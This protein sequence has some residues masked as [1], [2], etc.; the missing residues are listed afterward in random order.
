MAESAI[1]HCHRREREER[2]ECAKACSDEAREIH[3][4]LADRYADRA[5]SIEEG[6][7]TEPLI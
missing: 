6:Y 7:S 3:A 2:L 5:W 1:D 4:V